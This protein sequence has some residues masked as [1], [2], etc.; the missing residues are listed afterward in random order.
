MFLTLE[1]RQGEVMPMTLLPVRSS[2]ELPCAAIVPGD[3]QEESRRDMH[4]LA[5][6]PSV[7]S[8]GRERD[9]ARTRHLRRAEHVS[10]SQMVPLPDTYCASLGQDAVT[11]GIQ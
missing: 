1:D 9:D 8:S 5:V 3:R 11:H 10:C 7:P 2:P 4:A 6:H